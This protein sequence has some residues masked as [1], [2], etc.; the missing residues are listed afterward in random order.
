MSNEKHT[1]L[2]ESVKIAAELYPELKLRTPIKLPRFVLYT[3]ACFMEIFGKITGTEPMLQRQYLD[4][5]YH[6]KQDYDISDAIKELD[7]NPKS[8]K[9][10]LQGALAYLKNDWPC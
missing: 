10:A 2:T 7:F 3:I 9:Q 1:T 8:S 6:L 4:M 5:F